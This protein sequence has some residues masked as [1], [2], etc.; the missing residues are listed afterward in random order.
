MKI[1]EEDK[2]V[3]KILYPKRIVLLGQKKLRVVKYDGKEI[4]D[5]S[6]KVG[7]HVKL[8][9]VVSILDVISLKWSWY[10]HQIVNG[11][12]VLTNLS[13]NKLYTLA[14][15]PEEVKEELGLGESQIF[16]DLDFFTP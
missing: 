11:V 5:G 7:L 8:K 12:H 10:D 1:D 3:A 6:P 16:N 14:S 13:L 2:G 4:I 9:L 15:A